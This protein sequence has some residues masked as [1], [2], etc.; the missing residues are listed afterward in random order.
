MQ[1]FE[2]VFSHILEGATK[3]LLCRRIEEERPRETEIKR[4]CLVNV[5]PASTALSQQRILVPFHAKI[6]KDDAQ[7]KN[8][9]GSVTL[10][11]P[12]K[13]RR[14]LSLPG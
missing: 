8:L 13:T 1:T 6:T 14:R 9:I 11:L 10:E 3:K 5:R 2:G 4:S 7:K 12:I